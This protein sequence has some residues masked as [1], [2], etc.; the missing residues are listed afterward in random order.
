[1][2]LKTTVLLVLI[3][4]L[5]KRAQLGDPS[6]LSNMTVYQQEM[7]ADNTAAEI[8]SKISDFHTLA[9]SAYDPNGLESLQT[10][11]FLIHPISVPY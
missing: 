9:V 7:L 10:L 3:L 6:F 5:C 4:L 1:M 2:L 8:R 11:V